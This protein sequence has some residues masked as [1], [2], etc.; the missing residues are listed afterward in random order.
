MIVVVVVVVVSGVFVFFFDG[1]SHGTSI[2]MVN[3]VTTPPV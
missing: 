2:M 1:R 3:T